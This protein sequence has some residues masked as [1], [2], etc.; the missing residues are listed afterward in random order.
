[1]KMEEAVQS[2]VNGEC[3]Q[4]E[5]EC[6]SRFILLPDGFLDSVASPNTSRGPSDTVAILGDWKLIN[7]KPHMET[8]EVIG[9]RK[10]TREGVFLE[11]TEDLEAVQGWER[12]NYFYEV[13]HGTYEK[14]VKPKGK[15]REE[16]PNY[17]IASA[18][19]CIADETGIVKYFREWEK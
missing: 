6:G 18:H 7:P 4:I 8:V 9:W 17:A 2:L 3:D 15:H 19:R 12:Q 10:R 16:I 1:M 13:V 5:S 11:Y 14:P